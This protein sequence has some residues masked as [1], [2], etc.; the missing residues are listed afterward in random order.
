[1]NHIISNIII[2]SI[3]SDKN[4]SS[5]KE[6]RDHIENQ[7]NIFEKAIMINSTD[8]LKLMLIDKVSQCALIDKLCIT[9]C[10]INF[11]ERQMNSVLQNQIV[12]DTTM[13]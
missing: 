8:I 7:L 12:I 4:N 3:I 1:M 9:E 6:I 13:I 5:N 10:N 11:S 2:N